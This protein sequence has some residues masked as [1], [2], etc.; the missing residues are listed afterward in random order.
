MT[1]DAYSRE[2][3]F[4]DSRVPQLEVL[5]AAMRPGVE[6]VMLDG[7]TD[8]LAQ[9]ADY[10]IAHPGA[11]AV[12]V[13][14][15]GR[16]GGV[17]LGNQWLD[18]DN[19]DAHVDA[20]AQIGQSLAP[21]GDIL[22]YGCNLAAGTVGAKFLNQLAQA[23]GANVAASDDLTGS[24]RLGGDWQLE[25]QAGTVDTLSA[26]SGSALQ[27][28]DA[29]LGVASENFD[30]VIPFFEESTGSIDVNGWTFFSS[31]TTDFSVDYALN[32]VGGGDDLTLVWNFN[33]NVASDF[34]FRSTLGEDFKLNSFVF[35]LINGPTVTISGYRNGSEVVGGETFNTSG[36]YSGTHISYSSNG[37][38][39]GTAT[40]GSAYANVDEIRFSL[41]PGVTLEIDDISISPV[42]VS[43]TVEVTLSDYALSTGETAFVTFAFSEAVKGFTT[44][45]VTVPYGALG[46]LVLGG[47]G[48]TWTAT[49]TPNSAIS[50]GSN[51]ITVDM[52]GVSSVASSTPGAATTSSAA[53]AIDTVSPS[54]VNVASSA[55]D[56]TYKTGDAVSVQVNF[57]ELVIVTGTP[58]LTLETG[59]SDRV[60]YY[61]SGSG[62]NTLN[63]VYTVQVGDTS[64]DL[65]YQGATALA[66]S[67][68]TIKDAAGNPA[69]L[70]L[71][72]PGAAGSLGASGA[73]IID[74]VAPVP[75]SG[76]VP[77]DTTYGAGQALDFTVTYGEAVTVDTT[78]GV[79]YIALMLGAGNTV[80]ADYL[81]GSGTNALTFRYT[82]AAGDQDADGIAVA[83]G[84]TLSGGTM[85]DAAGNDAVTTGI[86]FGSTA[87]VLLDA[88]GPSVSSISLMGASTTN[89]SSVDYAVLFSKVVTGVDAGDFVLASTGTASG[90]VTGV[91]GSGNSYTVTVSGITGD[92]TLRLDLKGSDTSIIDGAGNAVAAGFTSGQAYT[93]DNVAPAAPSTPDLNIASDSG[94]SFTDNI[95]NVSTPT[96]T[97]SAEAN[98]TVTLYGTDGTELGTTQA[99]VSGLW[100]ITSA[101]LGSGTHMLTA[102]ATD[103][104]GNTSAASAGVAVTIDTTA[105]TAPGTPDLAAGSDSGMSSSDDITS[106]NTPTFTGSAEAN[107]TIALF[108]TD[109]KTVLGSTT[110]DGSGNW[111]ITSTILAEGSH[112]LTTKATDVAGNESAASAGLV[113]VIDSTAPTLAITSSASTLR[114]GETATITFQFSEDPGASFT[115]ADVTVSGGVLGVL[116]GTGPIRTATFT[117]TTGI[118]AGTASIS[119]AADSYVDATG[120]FGGAGVSPALMVDTLAPAAPSAPDLAAGSDSGASIED[121]VTRSTTLTLTGT[122]E[123]NST[124]RLYD[125]DGATVLG[126][127]SADG[128]GNWS[129]TSTTL[130]EGAHTLTAKAA[131]AVG[132][133]SAAS[134]GLDLVIDTA[135]PT[136]ASATVNGSQLILTYSES[137]LLDAAVLPAAGDFEVQAA[138]AVRGVSAVAIDAAAKTVILTLAAAVSAGQAVTVG[139]TDHDD[140][141]AIRDA[142]GNDAV[143]FGAEA[144]DNVTPPAPPPAPPTPPVANETIDGVVVERVMVKH[145]DGSTS[146]TLV[147]PVVQASRVDVIGNDTL[148][149]IPLVSSNS[150]ATLL[151]AQLPIGYGLQVSGMVVPQTADSA[152]QQLIQQ[153]EARTSA[154]SSS[155]EQ[156]LGGALNFGQ[157][158]ASVPPLLVQAIVPTSPISVPAPTAPLII[159]GLPASTDSPVSALVIDARNLPNGSTLQLDNVDFA[160]VVGAVRITG[161]AGSQTVWADDAAQHIV[162]GADDDVLHGGGGDDTVGSE[163]GNDV[164]YGDAGND[165]LFG[166]AGA[167]RL[168]GGSDS[169]TAR[170]EGSRDDYIVAQDHS[171][172]T[173]QSK[174]DPSDIDTL[175][176]IETLSFADGDEAVA[177]ADQLVW[178]AGL[179]RQV[180]G[181]QADVAGIQYWAGQVEEGRDA[182]DVALCFLDSGEAGMALSFG[183]ASA[184][185]EAFYQGLLGRAADAPGQAYWLDRLD[186]GLSLHDLAAGF[187]GS[188]E[189]Q[190]QNLGANE[191]NFLG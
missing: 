36:S 141:N 109:G 104:V 186:D 157:G 122:A 49:Y 69:V 32:M 150:G 39:Y 64:A 145:P 72:T 46:G 110:S 184:T 180:L 147:I 71:A 82:V 167:D 24:V 175:I 87:G 85:R 139:Y 114:A 123:P 149:D 133:V 181:R 98:S 154:G 134:A 26:F 152:L 170:Y 107:S 53:F 35:G 111:S 20:L 5:L 21:D 18:S 62:T 41:G 116:N 77:A 95:T 105:P 52:S 119:V 15:H 100:S 159:S 34:K 25:S 19:I 9:I 129:I 140:L 91:S 156:L 10:L 40:F 55:Q 3:V 73:I 121:N 31:Q 168:H 142:A 16:A 47:D 172:I 68:G 59:P 115:S 143:S 4:I 51:V 113:V 30:S 146:Q 171:V 83:S 169:D 45:D 2:F 78:H 75:T 131:D 38:G 191:W 22:F 90:T 108:D 84:I 174:A 1:S 103:A 60:A 132:N 163:G 76:G 189:M 190:A 164:L 28:Y 94:L 177:Y 37:A 13:V 93:F 61:A 7:S 136:F 120:N 130:A 81:A 128:S 65:D 33:R 58:G 179:Y 66:L 173:V 155:Q 125:A 97:G 118:D 92:G 63:F 8:G 79:P 144:V 188:G 102:K 86:L 23:T 158:L 151:G 50:S 6:L 70:A 48:R 56:G 165:T 80:Q 43:P 106:E 44:D 101:P 127:T 14:S 185:L 57:S 88:A 148:A 54:V 160:A 17:E 187:M 161:G 11:Q 176:N 178:I 183:D 74:A 99:D 112:T 166:G 182:G 42:A 96:L 67:G 153:I 117:P 126:T 135:E 137:S 12:H 29:T 162:L 89:A 27:D 138:G 124:V